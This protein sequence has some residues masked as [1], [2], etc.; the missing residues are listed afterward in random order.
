MR[1]SSGASFQFYQLQ[2][3]DIFAKLVEV[4]RQFLSD[5][6]AMFLLHHLLPVGLMPSRMSK[7][8]LNA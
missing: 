5:D 7:R 8:E 4:L 3:Y 2:V 6:L 1:R